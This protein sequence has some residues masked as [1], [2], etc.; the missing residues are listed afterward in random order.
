MIC[1]P[2]L[3]EVYRWIFFRVMRHELGPDRVRSTHVAVP[4]PVDG[5]ENLVSI[6]IIMKSTTERKVYISNAHHHTRAKLTHRLVFV[7]LDG[8]RQE[9]NRP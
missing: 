3:E 4:A 2:R 8:L 5:I 9:P 1:E 6:S 7:C